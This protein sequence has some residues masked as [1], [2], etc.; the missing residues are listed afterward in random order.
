M[1]P[2]GNFGCSFKPCYSYKNTIFM[3]ALVRSC[4]GLFP[5]C[6]HAHVSFFQISYYSLALFLSVNVYLSTC[7]GCFKISYVFSHAQSVVLCKGCSNVLCQPTGGRARLTDG[8]CRGYKLPGAHK[9]LFW[10]KVGVNGY[11]MLDCKL[12]GSTLLW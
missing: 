8:E 11:Y 1:K 10:V 3:Q 2:S 9:L 12:L 4:L 5:L 6:A 7:A